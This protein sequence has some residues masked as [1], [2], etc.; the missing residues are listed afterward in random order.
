M[1]MTATTYHGASDEMRSL[2]TDLKVPTKKADAIMERFAQLLADA[3]TPTT[4]WVAGSRPA[5]EYIEAYGLE[6]GIDACGNASEVSPIMP[7][8]PQGFDLPELEYVA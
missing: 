6:I 7:G 1:G 2:L 4:V 5:V 8:L 3:Q